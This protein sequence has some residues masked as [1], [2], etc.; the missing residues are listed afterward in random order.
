M[1]YQADWQLQ[2][3]ALWLPPQWYQMKQGCP[4]C[5]RD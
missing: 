4:S 3:G 2:S 5:A 1:V